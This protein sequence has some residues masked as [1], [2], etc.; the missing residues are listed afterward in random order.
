MLDSLVRVSRRVSDR[1]FANIFGVLMAHPPSA[2]PERK[3]NFILQISPATQ[4]QGASLGARRKVLNPAA[5][6]S[7][8]YNTPVE[9]TFLRE[10]SRQQS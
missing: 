5:G 1:H 4:Q 8:G 10:F 6:S 3:D 2:R 7:P 9:V